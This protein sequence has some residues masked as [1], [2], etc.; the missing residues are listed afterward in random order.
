MKYSEFLQLEE[1]LNESNQ[2]F[3]APTTEVG[4][5]DTKKGNW[6]TRW[7]LMKNKLNKN[8][9]KIQDNVINKIVQKYLPTILE[10][11]IKTA[12][13]IA[14]LFQQQKQPKEVMK[15][16]RNNL[17]TVK[18]VQLQQIDTIH[19]SINNFVDS[20]AA[21]LNTKIDNSKMNEK[22]KLNIKNYWLLLTTQ[23]K[24]NAFQHMSDKI[25]EAVGKIVGNNMKFYDALS[26]E[27]KNIEKYKDTYKQQADQKNTEIKATEQ[28]MQ[29]NDQPD[30]TTKLAEIGKQYKYKAAGSGNDVVVEILQIMKDENL[31]Q[32]KSTKGTVYTI[33]LNTKLSPIEETST[34]EVK[35]PVTL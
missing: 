13:Q 16:M 6:F 14:E 4:Q 27:K 23:I 22:N 7:G 19:K 12:Q 3:E 21:K 30:Q 29:K 5:L 8:A 34:S 10:T 1:V 20:S 26:D 9:K 18:Q 17:Q 28:E 24:M 33:P 11:E 25:N 35:R 2:L 31:Y 32:V 15:V